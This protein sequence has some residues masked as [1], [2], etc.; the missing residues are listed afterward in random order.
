MLT[1]FFTKTLQGSLFRTFRDVIMD[2]E[3]ISNLDEVEGALIPEE[4]VRINEELAKKEE[5]N[6]INGGAAKLLKLQPWTE[7]TKGLGTN[8]VALGRALGRQTSR[9]QSTTTNVYVY[10]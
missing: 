4:R 2:Y 9:L 8:H 3:H 7:P 5:A 10:V 6:I 1:D